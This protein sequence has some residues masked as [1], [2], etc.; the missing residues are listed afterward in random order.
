MNSQKITDE[1][2]DLYEKHGSDDYIGEPVS[3]LEHMSQSAQLAIDQ[4]FDDEVV[5]AA[6]FHDIGHLCAKDAENMG[7]FGVKSHERIGAD[8]LRAKGY[9][10]KIAKLV[11][12]H[13]QA[14]RYLTYKSPEYYDRLSEASRRTL[15]FQ[16]G[17]MSPEEATAFEND[18]L[19][20][21]SIKMRTWD[22]EAK[23]ENIPI[24][25]IEILKSKSIKVLNQ[26]LHN[27]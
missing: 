18:L 2:F 19:F 16:G 22:E 20:H 24:I 27:G 1:I 4:G 9:P 8:F 3:Q 23:L 6:F 12:N 5:L 25:D 10:E 26:T 11:E 13:V 15:E 17:K 21:E 14:K 7:G